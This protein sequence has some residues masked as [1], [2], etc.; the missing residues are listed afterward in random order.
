[1]LFGLRNAPY[2]FK[3]CMMAIFNDMI[4]DFME[5]LMDDLSFFVEYYDRC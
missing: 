1:M 2:T 3:E 4:E 5:I